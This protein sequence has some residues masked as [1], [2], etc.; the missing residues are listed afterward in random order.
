[1]E[2]IEIII[3]IIGVITPVLIEIFKFYVDK[4][5]DNQSSNISVSGNNNYVKQGDSVKIIKNYFNV[6]NSIQTTK[7]EADL[8]KILIGA[9]IFA[10]LLSP[11]LINYSETIRLIYLLSFIALMII[12]S[13]S[14]QN[15]KYYLNNLIIN[16]VLLILSFLF[17]SNLLWSDDMVSLYFSFKENYNIIF[18]IENLITNKI[19]LYVLIRI[20]TI[21][22]LNVFLCVSTIAQ[23][24]INI[25]HIIICKIKSV[26][27]TS[28]K[29][30]YIFSTYS[31]FFS[32]VCV[33]LNLFIIIIQLILQ[34]VN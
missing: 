21:L 22:L 29:R 23:C 11:L 1:M 30:L 15:K 28:L 14:P 18:L 10:I 6:N 13:F 32:F 33:L 17:N 24:L 12:N 9:F 4:K 2:K 16:I 20:A 27:E 7:K 26:T 25:I 34:K 19:D 3:G 31:N 5:K 8:D